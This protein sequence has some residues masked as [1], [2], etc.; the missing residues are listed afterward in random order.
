[1]RNAN[2]KS[3]EYIESLLPIENKT[4]KQSRQSA[5][6]IGLNAISLAAPEGQLLFFLLKSSQAQKVIEIGTL[7]G[8]SAQYIL[9]ALPSTGKLWTL[10]KSVQHADLARFSLTEEIAQGRC[11]ILVGDAKENLE[12]LAANGPFDAVFIDGNK[13]AYFDYFNWALNHIKPG[14]LIIADNTFLS[15]A[16][17]GDSTQQKFNAK[18]I[19]AVKKMNA[20]AFTDPRVTSVLIPTQ[21][22]LLVCRK[23]L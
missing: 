7:T 5:E 6:S 20:I 21:E 23:A 17:W 11:E 3:Y 16:V 12:T 1:M 22:G 14:G 19:E 4:M 18:Q 13:A 10:E 9:Q 2:P 8:L 15:G